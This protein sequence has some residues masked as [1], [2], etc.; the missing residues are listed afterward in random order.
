MV[1]QI[2]KKKG[3]EYNDAIISQISLRIYLFDVKATAAPNLSDD[4]ILYKLIEWMKNPGDDVHRDAIKITH[5]DS[6]SRYPK[7]LTSLKPSNQKRRP[8]IVA[9]TETVLVNDV[10]VPYAVGFMVVKPGDA[11]SSSSIKNVETS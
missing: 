1:D 6:K 9:D 2:V 10:H 3:E 5:S 4:D 8:F 11:L 7:S